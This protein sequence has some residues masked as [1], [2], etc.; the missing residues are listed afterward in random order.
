[1]RKVFNVNLRFAKRILYIGCMLSVVL[2]ALHLILQRNVFCY[3]CLAVAVI[4]AA[5]WGLYGRCPHCGRFIGVSNYEYC[6]HCGEK[7]E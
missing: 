3:I 5:V 4:T 6:P 1:V 2:F 7:I